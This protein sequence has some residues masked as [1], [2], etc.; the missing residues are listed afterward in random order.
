MQLAP[1]YVT[2]ADRLEA[3]AR[4]QIYNTIAEERFDQITRLLAAIC[5]VPAAFVSFIGPD[6]IVYKSTMNV[7]FDRTARDVSLCG[8]A[9]YAEHVFEVP[10]TLQ[11]PRFVD[12][13]HIQDEDKIRFYAGIALKTPDGLPIGMLAVI[14]Y[15]PRSLTPSQRDALGV[16]AQQVMAHIE[17][18]RAHYCLEH[19]AQMLAENNVRLSKQ[20]IELKQLN[21]GKDKFFSIIAHDLRAP[22]Q[23]LLGFSEVLVT[24]LEE[25]SLDEIRNMAGYLHDTTQATYHFL[26]NLLQWS[27]MESGRMPFKP[28]LVMLEY[29]FDRVEGALSAAA[30][31]KQI[32][33]TVQSPYDLSILADEPMVVCIV[34]NLVANAIK[35]TLPNGQIKVTAAMRQEAFKG[36]RAPY[37]ELHHSDAKEGI[38]IVV[39]DNGLGMTPAQQKQ[40]FHIDAN[41]TTLG[42]AGEA[43]TGLGLLLCQQFVER[44]GGRIEIESKPGQ[45]SLF[46]V[47]L[48]YRPPQMSCDGHE[49]DLTS[50]LNDHLTVTQSPPAVSNLI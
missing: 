50:S 25:M 41:M 5:E 3:L 21:A 33:L 23:G 10:D 26:D 43:G 13:S 28:T 1:I 49:H 9:L 16:L 15:R 4:Y 20:N 27:R 22:F 48:P 36:K 31:H 2:E 40:L 12:N 11:D 19:Q 14:D 17:L 24:D 34:H 29:V 42:T 7:K 44:H 46:R 38:E 45:G 30:L 37:G 35:F 39:Q 18:R 32:T 8:H 47:I 6:E